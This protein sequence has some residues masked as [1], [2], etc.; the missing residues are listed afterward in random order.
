MAT[1]CFKKDVMKDEADNVLSA[2][3]ENIQG[4]P[5]LILFETVF[6]ATSK[7]S[8]GG[9]SYTSGYN[10]ARVSVYNIAG[11]SLVARKPLGEQY[12]DETTLLLGFSDNKLWFCSKDKKKRLFALNALTLEPV[13]SQEEI[14]A[15]NPGLSEK[16]ANPEWYQLKQYFGFDQINNL[17]ILT[18]IEGYRYLLNPKTL[19]AEKLEKGKEIAPFPDKYY[20]SSVEY[21][22]QSIYPSGDIRK[23]LEYKSKVLNPELSYIDP[24]FI[25]ER[26]PKKL[27]QNAN[28]EI[29][30]MQKQVDSLDEILNESMNTESGTVKNE[31][32]DRATVR[33]LE[34]Q[35]REFEREIENGK[36]DVDDLE[37]RGRLFKNHLLLTA[38]NTFLL[39]H[40]SNT[41]KNAVAMLS[42][43][44]LPTEE[45]M[46][47]NWKTTL[48]NIFFN[49][50]DARET[51]D[52]KRVFSKGD[53]DFDFNFFEMTD[54]KIVM[55]Y[56]LYALCIDSKT[57]N[58]LWKFRI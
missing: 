45:K 4:K 36:K 22:G 46:T 50:S 6:Q 18:D 23:V 41:N 37:K 25:L 38:D 49:A 54:N 5:Y 26:D 1:S 40:R 35:K 7:S 14:F 11:G 32:L 58:V 20:T 30:S 28:S 15:K 43:I 39:L 8:G 47:E 2:Y 53:P 27:Y 42:S 21:K 29:N 12:Q 57:G 48:D 24:Q 3:V 16:L 9:V 55:V 44:S 31:P 10:D 52:F 56:M 34:H 51:D 17:L 13:I 33:E 19:K